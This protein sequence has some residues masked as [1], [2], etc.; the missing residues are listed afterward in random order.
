MASPVHAVVDFSTLL[1]S[2]ESGEAAVPCVADHGR[3]RL[4]QQ[5]EHP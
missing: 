5:I 2:C 3:F 1:P 4:Y